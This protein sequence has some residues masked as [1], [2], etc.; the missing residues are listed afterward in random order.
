MHFLLSTWWNNKIHRTETQYLLSSIHHGNCSNF[1]VG[2]IPGSLLSD[3][4]L[5]YRVFILAS[6][7]FCLFIWYINK[8]QTEKRK[9]PCHQ[10]TMQTAQTL[11]SLPPSNAPQ[12][13]FSEVL[14]AFQVHYKV[15]NHANL[16]FVMLVFL[17]THSVFM[18][19][20]SD[21]QEKNLNNHCTNRT[22][23][24]SRRVIF[25]VHYKVTNNE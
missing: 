24:T 12:T 16:E 18:I 17:F 7:S 5:I 3:Q 22:F 20:Y 13:H 23:L 1:L 15:T 11:T 9:T 25:Q 10:H 14:P 6:N 4:Q 21:L 2:G 19:Q 8:M